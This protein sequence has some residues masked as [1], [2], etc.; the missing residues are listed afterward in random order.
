MLPG[1]SQYC[2]RDYPKESEHQKSTTLASGDA[3]STG[4][5]FEN[6]NPLVGFATGVFLLNIHFLYCWRAI[7]SY[8]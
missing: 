3:P 7:G 6:T 8:F 2:V 4:Q 1:V 5:L